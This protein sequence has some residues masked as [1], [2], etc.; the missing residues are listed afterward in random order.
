MVDEG[1]HNSMV[2]CKLVK[3][4]CNVSASCAVDDVLGKML[5]T[6]CN[7][8]LIRGD[9]YPNL[10]KFLE[11]TKQR[12]DVLKQTGFD[13]AGESIRDS[14]MNEIKSR[15]QDIT[16][17]HRIINQWESAPKDGT[18][19]EL[20]NEGKDALNSVIMARIYSR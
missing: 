6:M 18:A 3:K 20:I 12:L 1:G 13:I 10:A 7:C 5:E 11:A 19:D 2:L 17:L 4:I 16:A 9:D 14:C 15:G 8:M